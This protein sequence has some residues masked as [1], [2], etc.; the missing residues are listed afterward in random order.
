MDFNALV[1]EIVKRVAQKIE[2]DVQ[3]T[4]QRRRLRYAP[5]PGFSF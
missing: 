3:D 1:D 4:G 2:A 5:S